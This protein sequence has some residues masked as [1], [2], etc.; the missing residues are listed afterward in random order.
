MRA[1][2]RRDLP[3]EAMACYVIAAGLFRQVSIREV[4]HCLA[5]GLRWAALGVPVR[6]SGESLISRARSRLG[7]A[8]FE[9]LR[10]ARVSALA[11][12]VGSYRGD[13]EHAQ[14]MA[15]LAHISRECWSWPTAAISGS[16]H[17][18]RLQRPEPSCSGARRR[19]SACARRVSGSRTGHGLQT[20][21]TPRRSLPAS[22]DA[23]RPRPVPDP[24]ARRALPRAVGDRERLRRG[25][26]PSAGTRGRAAEQ[27]P[28]AGPPGDRRADAR[29]LRREASDPPG[30]RKGP[31]INEVGPTV[32]FDAAFGG[33][34]S[35]GTCFRPALPAPPKIGTHPSGRTP[36][37]GLTCGIGKHISRRE[38]LGKDGLVPPRGAMV[39]S[40]PHVRR[41]LVVWS[42]FIAK[43]SQFLRG[44]RG[45]PLGWSRR[46]RLCSDM[47]LTSVR[48]EVAL[49]G[50]TGPRPS[51]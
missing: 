21:R 7:T 26:D 23:F 15:L 8:P 34:Q 11:L 4:L 33:G 32:V 24:R 28:G 45:I 25:Q 2:R 16:P 9:E 13:S 37:T 51:K 30:R 14:A 41:A 5:D 29:A 50:L 47:V 31:P 43:R 38:A 27:D 42:S 39:E 36:I 49:N 17:S 22:D 6:I 40:L 48:S 19:T 18:R 10:R 1:E 46:R 44:V 35:V 20:R 12:R 3:L